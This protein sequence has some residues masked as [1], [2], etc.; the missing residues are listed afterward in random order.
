MRGPVVQIVNNKRLI[1]SSFL[2]KFTGLAKLGSKMEFFIF[3]F[4]QRLKRNIE[5]REKGPRW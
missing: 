5:E 4:K 2:R 3:L 1:P